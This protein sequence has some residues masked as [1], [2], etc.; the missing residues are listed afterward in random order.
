[1]VEHATSQHDRYFE[2][3]TA[4]H[5]RIIIAAQL[6][7]LFQ[8]FGDVRLRD[9]EPLLRKYVPKAID[10]SESRPAACWALGKIHEGESVADLIQQFESRLN[11][12]NSMPP[13]SDPVRMMCA[14]GLGRMKAESSLP[15]L[16][17]FTTDGSEVSLACWW[18]IHALTGKM[19]PEPTRYANSVMGWFLQPIDEHSTLPD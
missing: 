16:N 7:Q 19:P 15:S 4:L 5:E 8:L 1:L 14:L 12:V 18:S 2:P 9:A 11:D 10:L 13:E 3:S 17:R 6:T